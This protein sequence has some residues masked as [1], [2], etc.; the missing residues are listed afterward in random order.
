MNIPLIDLSVQHSQIKPELDAMLDRV[1]ADNAFIHG[2]YVAQFERQFADYLDVRHVIGVA[3]GT[4]ALHLT[5]RACGIGPG[6]E[7]ITAANTF[8][9][10]TEAITA[11][12]A[13]IVL[14]DIDPRTYLIDPQQI[15]RLIT[16][17]T[18]AIIPVH[19]Y[20]QPADMQTIMEIADHRHLLV[21]EDACQAHGARAG[22]RRVGTIGTAGCFS[23]YPGKNL[24]ALGDA[25]AIVTNDD[26]LADR[27]RLL[28]NHGSRIKYHH[29]I[30]GWNSRLD[31]IQ[32]GALSIKLSHLDRWNAERA[33]IATLYASHLRNSGVVTPVAAAGDHVWHLYVIETPKRAALMRALHA[34]GVGAAIH[35]PIPLHLQPAYSH[36]GYTRG[37]FPHAEQA[38]DRILSLPMYPG[39]TAPQI[40]QVATAI[41][42]FSKPAVAA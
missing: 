1:I 33:T 30:E 25:G 39:L 2:S 28:T 21:I 32:A 23:F 10:T 41:W 17:R 26:D 36:L 34:R 11:A 16:P 7:V 42:D 12:G 20:G 35:Y 24:G 3:N 4:D 14:A 40:A 15:E 31:T 38:A 18:K 6:D 37:A 22:G 13:S 5:L 8:I 29:E 9:A 19:L 27:I